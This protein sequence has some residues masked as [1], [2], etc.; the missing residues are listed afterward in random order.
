M[1]QQLDALIRH[2]QSPWV[3]AAL[4][5]VVLCL[6]LVP[7]LMR[8]RK[9]AETRLIQRTI[10]AHSDAHEHDAVI[11][12]GLDG[13]FFV[14][15]LLLLRGRIIAM[16]VL[17]KKG[18]I[19]GGEDIEEWTCVQNNRTEKFSNPLADMRLC[20]QQI[21]HALEFEHV[22]AC[23]LFGRDSEFPKGVPEGV[24]SLAHL[25]EELD[26]LKGSDDADEAARQAWAHLIAMVGEGRW[27]LNSD[28][29]P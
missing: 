11:S 12:D 5:G 19:F 18:Y 20:A 1:Q 17:S 23:V 10:A 28:I 26:A 6:L 2:L 9:T 25:D 27:E 8:R 16:K 29:K 22:A 15:Y 24:L 21:R 14:D 7:W 13:F 4:A 3:A